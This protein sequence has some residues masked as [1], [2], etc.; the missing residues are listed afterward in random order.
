MIIFRSASLFASTTKTSQNIRRN[1]LRPTLAFFAYFLCTSKESEAPAG[2]QTGNLELR[3]IT[4]KLL[5]FA[6][7]AQPT[8]LIAPRFSLRTVVKSQ[9]ADRQSEI[10]LGRGTNSDNACQRKT[11]GAINC[12]LRL[13]T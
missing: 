4:K 1:P 8:A 3:D 9:R 13:L 6:G 10:G 2:A 7:S 11:S 12:T 5:G